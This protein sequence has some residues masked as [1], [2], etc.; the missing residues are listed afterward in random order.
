MLITYA[1]TIL[2]ILGLLAGWV[3]VQ[4][5]SRMFAARHPEFGPAREE[6]GGCGGLFCLCKDKMAC[7]KQAL[8]NKIRKEST[9][10]E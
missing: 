7:P 9:S 8:K 6:G 4:H 10:S 1:I 2:I 3:G 5:L